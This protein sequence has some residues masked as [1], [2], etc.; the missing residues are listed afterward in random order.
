MACK[1]SEIAESIKTWLNSGSYVTAVTA[2][3]RWAPRMERK[4]LATLQVS[5][6][7][8]AR[9][10]TLL[11]RG[12][13]VRGDFQPV[14]TVTKAVDHETN[15]QVDQLGELLEQLEDRIWAM[16][17]ITIASKPYAVVETEADISQELLWEDRIFAGYITLT[18]RQAGQ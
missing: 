9:R 11:N 17:V 12:P 14:I 7:P 16:D 4:D 2:D 3:R 1:A 5:V 18:V 10:V 13:T 15:S 8:G 6:L